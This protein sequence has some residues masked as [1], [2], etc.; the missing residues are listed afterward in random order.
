VRPSPH[1]LDDQNKDQ[2]KD[3]DLAEEG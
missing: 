2:N 1:V 3:T